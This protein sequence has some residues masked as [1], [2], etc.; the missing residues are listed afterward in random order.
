[1]NCRAAPAIYDCPQCGRDDLTVFQII[2][3]DSK[4]MC[5]ECCARRH[6]AKRPVS[7]RIPQRGPDITLSV[8][9]PR[10]HLDRNAVA[11]AAYRFYRYAGSSLSDANAQHVANQFHISAAY[12]RIIFREWRNGKH[13]AA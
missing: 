8:P 9:K 12:V 5:V 13:K 7:L 2:V 11:R 10:T 3:V 6:A 4:R 1:V